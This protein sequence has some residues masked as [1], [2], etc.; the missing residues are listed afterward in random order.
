MKLFEDKAKCCGC[1]LCAVVCKKNA[2]TM[3]IDSRGF[4][5]PQINDEICIE[6]GMC[7]KACSYNSEE[8]F[9]N[10]KECYAGV[11]INKQ[12]LSKSA[13]G[14]IFATIAEQFIKLGGWICGSVMDFQNGNASCYHLV[15]NKLDDI[16]RIQGSKYV[17]SDITNALIEIKEL[18]Q[19]KEK[20]LFCGTPC[21]VSA[22]KKMASDYKYL[23]TI[24]IIC[25]GVPS[26]QLFNEFLKCKSSKK[27]QICGFVFRDK[28]KG[29]G[30][31]AKIIEKKKNKKIE[32]VY[33]A[34]LLSYYHYFLKSLIQRE[35]CYTCKYAKEKRCSDMTIGDYWGMQNVFSGEK[36]IDFNQSWSCILVNNQKGKELLEKNEKFF[37]LLKTKLDDIKI[38]NAQLNRPSE[39]TEEREKILDLF[40]NKGY[41]TVEKEFKRKLGLKYYGLLLRNYIYGR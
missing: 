10:P 29:K 3:E 30:Y 7:V 37:K 17:Q 14:G 41:K 21:Q 11:S 23:Y 28:S 1:G 26:L 22:V 8:N 18:I 33:P 24:D 9:Y 36:Q 40:E 35:N 6:C 39:K 2:I 38:G 34:H 12:M 5:Y 15:T 27:R 32:K 19:K 31:K 13:S 16:R 25:H 20:I 4:I